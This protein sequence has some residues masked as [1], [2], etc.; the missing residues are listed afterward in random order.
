MPG[1]SPERRRGE[2]ILHLWE[3]SQEEAT[4]GARKVRFQA[5]K[6]EHE[7]HYTI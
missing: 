6:V 3:K 1:A 5:D 4:H 7:R 2:S